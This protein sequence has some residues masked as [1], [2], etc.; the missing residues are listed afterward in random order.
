[1]LHIVKGRAGSGKTAW[2]REKIKESIDSDKR[3]LL[4]VADQFSFEN[5]R[6]MLSLLGA[7][8]MKKID[9]YSF[10][11]LAVSNIDSKILQGKMFAD[12]GVRMAYMSEAITQ[13]SGDLHVFSKIRHNVSGLESFIDL[14]KEFE[15]CAITDEVITETL[16]NMPEGLLK[17]KLYEI[18]LINEAYNALLHRSYFDDTECLKYFND[19]AL[20]NAFFKDRVLFLDSFKAFSD[21]FIY[22]PFLLI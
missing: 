10:P 5:E 3:P 11:R 13:L 1:M 2:L 9:V 15:T 19:F 17:D 18:N 14:N 6:A 21:L 16:V 12:D 8:N 20:E 4:L 22:S 7:K